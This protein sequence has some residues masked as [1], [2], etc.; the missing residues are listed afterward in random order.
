MAASHRTPLYSFHQIEGT[1]ASRP[2]CK[3]QQGTPAF[4]QQVS[5]LVLFFVVVS[6]LGLD[7][8]GGEQHGGLWWTVDLVAQDA[9][10]HLQEEQLL[11]DVLDQLLRHVL[12][13]ELGPELELQRVLLLHVLGRHLENNDNV[14]NTRNQAVLM[15]RM[16][17]GPQSERQRDRATVQTPQ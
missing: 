10:L 14:V 5:R 13:E 4:R 2:P 8:V 1:P 7:R 3:N 17:P 16:G 15:E 6:K 11:G 9:L 12:W